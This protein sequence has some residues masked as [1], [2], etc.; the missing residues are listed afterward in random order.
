[1]ESSRESLSRFQS[2]AS[3]TPSYYPRLFGWNI[4]QN[5][6]Y[7]LSF[8]VALHLATQSFYLSTSGT[9]GCESCAG[10]LR[11]LAAREISAEDPTPGS[12]GC[13]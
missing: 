11:S 6:G 2:R 13:W 5:D 7:F 4:H 3:A 12:A 1:L 9:T 10:L 8:L